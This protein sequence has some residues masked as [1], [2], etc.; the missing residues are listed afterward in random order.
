MRL[1]L[2]SDLIIGS[3]CGVGILLYVVACYWFYT[4]PRRY[5]ANRQALD[6]LTKK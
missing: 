3:L 1:S 2:Q 4:V 5:Q 6:Y